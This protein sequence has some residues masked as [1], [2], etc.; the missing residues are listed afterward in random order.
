MNLSVL[1]EYDLNFTEML[2][3]LKSSGSV[4]VCEREHVRQVTRVIVLPSAF[5]IH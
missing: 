2:S 5:S 3:Y 1:P 4:A